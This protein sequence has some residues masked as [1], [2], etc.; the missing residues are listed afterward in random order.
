MIFASEAQRDRLP[1]RKLFRRRTQVR[2][3]CSDRG[4]DGEYVAAPGCVVK[5]SEA[6]AD[7]PDVGLCAQ[8]LNSPAPE[9]FSL[10]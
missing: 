6:F 10:A 7:N 9:M 4:P 3:R 5:L 1:A 2:L 8:G